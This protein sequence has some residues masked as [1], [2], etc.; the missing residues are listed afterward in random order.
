MVL[1]EK[2]FSETYGLA[3]EEDGEAYLQK[4]HQ[5][6]FEWLIPHKEKAKKRTDKGDYWLGIAR[7]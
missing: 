1:F 4:N 3:T 6:I 5:E 7:L 2:G